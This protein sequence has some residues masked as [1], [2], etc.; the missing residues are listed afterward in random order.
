LTIGFNAGSAADMDEPVQKDAEVNGG[1]KAVVETEALPPSGERI[2][3][4]SSGVAIEESSVKREVSPEGGSG[5]NDKKVMMAAAAFFAARCKQ[6][7]EPMSEGLSS[8]TEAKADTTSKETNC[9]VNPSQESRASDD[10]ITATN[11]KEKEDPITPEHKVKASQLPDSPSSREEQS[12]ISVD[13][14]VQGMDCSS[15]LDLSVADSL[16][17]EKCDFVESVAKPGAAAK[18]LADA[19]TKVEED[20]ESK[21]PSSFITQSAPQYDNEVFDEDDDSSEEIE[22]S[23]ECFDDS[24]SLPDGFGS[25][26]EV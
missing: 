10:K 20:E 18:P 3:G 21:T 5:N 17:L 13:V 11:T 15:A 9:L 16:E 26:A 1:E 23:I 24:A 2:K 25:E 12:G 19:N 14:F 7:P 22:E 4:R 8:S 6:Q